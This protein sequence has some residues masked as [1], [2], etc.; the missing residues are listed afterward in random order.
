MTILANAS[1]ANPIAF[2]GPYK[3]VD[4][5]G[6]ATTF[7]TFNTLNPNGIWRL[8]I[9]DGVSGDGGSVS[10]LSVT[11]TANSATAIIT[12]TPVNTSDG[13]ACTNDACNSITG[14]ITHTNVNIDDGNACTTDAC[15][16]T[17]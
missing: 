17:T 11:I 13:N 12:H 6:A 15:N 14:E 1:T 3:P 4:G 10:L 8:Y 9:G 7:S 5:N 2:P 16:S